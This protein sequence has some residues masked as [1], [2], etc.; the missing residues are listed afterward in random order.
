MAMG[1][2]YYGTCPLATCKLR[3]TETRNNNLFHL[4][5]LA[6]LR[7]FIVTDVEMHCMDSEC[8]RAEG[9]IMPRVFPSE[10]FIDAME[11]T[12]NQTCKYLIGLGSSL[13]YVIERLYCG[14]V[15]LTGEPFFAEGVSFVVPSKSNLTIGLSKATL[16]L[17]NEDAVKTIL[18][19]FDNSNNCIPSRPRSLTFRKLQWFFFLAFGAS[20]LLFLEMV[21]DKR[22]AG[23]VSWML[24][25]MKKN[26]EEQESEREQ[27]GS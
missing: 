23:R 24:Q 15:V 16:D 27:Q 6:L 8:H 2:S 13:R 22:R 7:T 1:W 18:D 19:L 20:V 12:K 5:F 11:A 21:F 25:R 17:K 10:N 3:H 4:F 26:E 14:K 9:W